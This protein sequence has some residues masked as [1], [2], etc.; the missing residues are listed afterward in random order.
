MPDNYVSIVVRANDQTKIDFEELK[1]RLAEVGR[2]VETAKVDVNDKDAVARLTS[3]NARLERLNRQVKPEIDVKGALRAEAQIAA[4]DASL[5]HLDDKAARSGKTGLIGKLLFGPAG[6][7][8]GGVAGGMALGPVLAAVAGEV[9]ALASG[10]AAAGLGV[11]AF[12]AVAIPAMSDLKSGLTALSTATDAYSQASLNLNQAIRRSPA[13]MSAYRQSLAGLEPDLRS[14]ARLL[15]DQH[16]TWEAMTA[17]QRANVTALANNKDA[18][19]NLLPD[20]K[21]A[22]TALMNQKTAWDDLT[23]AQQQAARSLQ[24][25]HRAYA[26]IAAALQPDVMKVFNDGL[27]VAN[28]LLPNLKPF[29]DTAANALD[30]MLKKLGQAVAPAPSG[31]PGFLARRGVAAPPP[32]GWQQFIAQMKQLEGPALT[33]IGAGFGKIGVAL[34]HLLTI[35]SKKDVV[36][37]INIAFDVLAGTINGLAFVIRRL[38][39]NW[40]KDSQFFADRAHFIERNFDDMRHAAA[41]WAHNV[42]AHFDEVRHDVADFA[43]NVAA[44]FGEIRAD[45]ARWAGDVGRDTGRVVSWFRGLPGRIMSALGNLGSLLISAG[46]DLIRGLIS[47][48][49]GAIPGLTSV[50]GWVHSLLGGGGTAPGGGLTRRKFS[51]GMAPAGGGASSSAMSGVLSGALIRP[52]RAPY[53]GPRPVT[54]EYRPA[55]GWPQPPRPVRITNGQ[56]L[57]AILADLLRE[58]SRTHYGGSAQRAYGYGPG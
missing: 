51:S 9:T 16:A 23:P 1:R 45:I 2:K 39:F 54:N 7:L 15:T 10:L 32:T 3:L 21:A 58:H 12:A 26:R 17:A 42:A 20:Q 52:H 38:M 55:A 30:A 19:K 29:A 53:Y 14:A 56:E 36:H 57:V 22:L 48:I 50:I 40:D 6:A 33:A 31:D 47:G 41:D 28:R 44:H 18:I 5:G 49:E 8:A 4:I 11:G 27:R 46:A 35:M 25:F 34:G 37:S 24:A 43:H 13:D